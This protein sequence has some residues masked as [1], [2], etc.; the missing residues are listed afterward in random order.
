VGKDTEIVLQCKV[1]RTGNLGLL[2]K[3]YEVR[4]MSYIISFIGNAVDA[5]D[6]F[7]EV[8][9]R[10]LKGAR[11][12]AG[13]SKTSTWIYTI[14]RNLCINFLAKKKESTPFSNEEQMV[15]FS[16]DSGAGVRENPVREAELRELE[17]SISKT[18]HCLSPK[19]KEA[20]LLRYFNGLSYKQI[21]KV[22]GDPIGTVG[23]RIHEA[24]KAMKVKLESLRELVEQ[25]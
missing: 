17:E 8:F 25:G 6:I 11:N 12:F 22:T 4:L 19:T 9:V 3:K 20:V 15:Q 18:V 5:E 24:L 10:I 1:G 21:A 2:A 14:T 16:A 13:A 23:Y 7:Q